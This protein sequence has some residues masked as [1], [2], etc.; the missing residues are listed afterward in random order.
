M[1]TT[2][3]DYDDQTFTGDLSGQTGDH[4]RFLECRFEGCDLS[5]VRLRRA[6]FNDTGLYAA[7][8]AGADLSES[9]LLDCV[10]SGGRLG[11]LALHGADL[12]R[13][14]FEGCK[15]EFLNLRGAT[16]RDV[17]FVDCQLVEPDF[18]EA[19]L[20]SVGFSGSRLV[21]PDFGRSKLVGVDL[22]GADVQ[23]PR[24]IR[25]LGGATISRLQLIDFA[26]AFAAEIGVVVTD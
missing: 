18:A 16:L 7:Y 17:T 1:L 14:R 5:E 25:D 19:R 20:T 11:A 10:I 24:G 2:E 9:T 13:V 26:D 3:F 8:G 21:A 6:R 12:T 4:S 15:I 22:S 23:A